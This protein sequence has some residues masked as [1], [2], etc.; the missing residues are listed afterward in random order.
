MKTK[1]FII[2]VDEYNLIA[3]EYMDLISIYDLE[4]KKTIGYVSNL[5]E[6]ILYFDALGLQSINKD[7]RYELIKVFTEYANTSIDQR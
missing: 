2:K 1:E 3:H 7:K 6:N 4:T 5:E